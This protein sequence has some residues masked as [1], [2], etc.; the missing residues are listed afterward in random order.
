MLNNMIFPTAFCQRISS[1]LKDESDTFFESLQLEQ[2]TAVRVNPKKWRK[3]ISAEKIPWCLLGFYL[4]KRP[5]FTLDPWFHAGA[6]YVQEP[7]SM[8]LEQAFAAL[9]TP[10]KPRLILDLCAAPGGKSTH[11]LSLIDETD[12]L[13]TNE[14]IKSRAAVLQENIN[15][16]GYSNVVVTNNDPRDFAKLQ[17][18]FDIVAVDAPCSGEG[19]F[20]K[21]IA[22]IDEWSEANA[23][24]CTARQQRI[25]SDAWQCLKPGGFLIYS[26]CT[27][28]PEENEHNLSWLKK[29]HSADSISIPLQPEWNITTIDFEE[30]TGYQFYP[31]KTRSEGFFLGILQ[32]PEN[33]S[34]IFKISTSKKQ[35]PSPSK[36]GATLQE[37]I[38][39]SE[40]TDFM[41]KGE[42]VYCFKNQHIPVLKTLER[43][44]NIFQAGLPVAAVKA[45]QL[46]PHPVLAHNTRYNRATFPD[47]PLDLENALRFLRRENLIATNISNGWITVSY[48]NIPL[49]WIKN[50][51][52]RAN[53]HFP[54]EW[55]IR[56]EL[57]EIPMLWH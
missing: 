4:D 45:G 23:A 44:L 7:A 25:L 40:K 48:E 56:M 37:W 55:R 31:H 36:R 50:I 43:Y 22:A 10:H 13:V 2:C 35:I 57:R 21:D 15:K 53:N 51:G 24:L 42:I 17:N 5:S 3:E 54:K 18:L 30:I 27:F 16:W 49:G 39:G 41:E 20:R 47:I 26:T 6:Y 33:G 28:N 52:T 46:H 12:L 9:P 1:I 32:K 19:L 34:P 29:Q 8:F 11:I 38:L 14:V